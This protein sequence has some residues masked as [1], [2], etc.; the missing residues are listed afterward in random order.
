MAQFHM[1]PDEINATITALVCEMG[2]ME[3]ETY[4]VWVTYGPLRF[5]CCDKSA[6]AN[7]VIIH[8]PA[9]V[10]MAVLAVRPPPRPSSGFV[11]IERIR[12]DVYGASS[13][14]L[15]FPGETLSGVL[16]MKMG[17]IKKIE[18][19]KEPDA[20]FSVIPPGHSGRARNG[21][22]TSICRPHRK[23]SRRDYQSAIA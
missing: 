4:S 6:G 17:V 22:H 20:N 9:A 7:V 1:I 21:Q 3:G 2:T 10:K 13:G 18:V 19:G 11:V 16:N 15:Q 12:H 14:M 23:K 8:V 5:G